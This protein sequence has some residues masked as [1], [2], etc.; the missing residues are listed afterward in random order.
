MKELLGLLAYKNEVGKAKN[1]KYY[2]TNEQLMNTLR[3]K[4]ADSQKEHPH[5]VRE[6]A[7]GKKEDNNL[8]FGRATNTRYIHMKVISIFHV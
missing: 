2:K 3:A 7:I 5:V 6:L 4:I 8:K 1:A